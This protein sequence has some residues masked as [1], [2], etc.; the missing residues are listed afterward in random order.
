MEHAVHR[1][2]ACKRAEKEHSTYA[3]QE[4]PTEKTRPPE[5]EW[6]CNIKGERSSAKK[7]GTKGKTERLTIKQTERSVVCISTGRGR[8]ETIRVCKLSMDKRGGATF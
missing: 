2:T 7:Q 5:A 4:H 6:N 1:E 8:K 3:R